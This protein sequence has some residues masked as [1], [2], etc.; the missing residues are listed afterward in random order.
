LLAEASYAET[1]PAEIVGA[2]SSALDVGR[3]AA[4]AGVGRLVLTHLM[5]HTDPAEAMAAAA[6]E[7]SG[8]VSVAQ[9]G[10]SLD[11]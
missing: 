8:P 10:V 6:R 7:F 5:P 2:L 3:Q 4:V 9:A 11:I 1:V